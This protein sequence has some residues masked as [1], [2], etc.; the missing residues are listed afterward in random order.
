MGEQP[1]RMVARIGATVG[2][3]KGMQASLDG[4]RIV[5]LV[6]SNLPMDARVLKSARA[7]AAAGGDLTVI[8]SAVTVTERTDEQMGNFRAIGLPLGHHHH[9]RRGARRSWLPRFPGYRDDDVAATAH[10]RLHSERTPARAR[11]AIHDARVSVGRFQ[12]RVVKAIRWRWDKYRAPLGLVRWTT[13]LPELHEFSDAVS[14]EIVELRPTIL[15][16]HDVHAIHV[17]NHVKGMLRGEGVDTVVVYDAHEYVRGA[18]GHKPAVRAAWRQ[19][20][21]RSI[22]SADAVIT[23]S[24]PIAEALRHYFNLR[25]LP[26]VVLNTP[27]RTEQASSKRDLRRDC[28]L[29]LDVPLA[30]YSGVLRLPRGVD[31][32]VRALPGVPSVHLAVVC[33]PGINAPTVTHLRTVIDEAGVSDRVHLL[34]PVPSDSIV[35]FIASA[36]LGI[37]PLRR[38]AD[39]HDMALPNKLFDYIHAGLPLVVSSALSMAEFV[40]T[41]ALGEVFKSG[42]PADCARALA[43]AVDGDADASFKAKSVALRN[44]FS[45]ETQSAG[46]L[47]AYRTAQATRTSA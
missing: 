38:G 30:V 5:M 45:W 4:E 37:H 43:R 11:L 7:V 12:R 20:E 27:W 31:D 35:S 9:F 41:N 32:V 16:A 19:V 25:V 22:G 14:S 15:H 47:R 23:V 1:P 33:V 3:K 8:W 21:K 34:D 6:L 42:D 18:G 28:G 39:N 29:A 40:T 13:E 36:D 46:I 10:A 24:E 2:K 17:A 44:E 26:E